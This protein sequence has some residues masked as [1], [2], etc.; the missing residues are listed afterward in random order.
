VNCAARSVVIRQ[1]QIDDKRCADSTRALSLK[2]AEPLSAED[3]GAQAIED[4][5]PTKWHLQHTSW[6]VET[7]VLAPRMPGYALFDK[8]CGYCFNSYYEQVG[9]R[10]PRPKRRL[11]TRPSLE[12]LRAYREQVDA[13]L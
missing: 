13:A 7:F 6:F 1:I 11:L 9:L 3:M 4:A 12:R 5:S 10:Q 8:S 2:L